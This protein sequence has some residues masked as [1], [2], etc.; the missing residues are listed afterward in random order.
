MQVEIMAGAYPSPISRQFLRWVPRLRTAFDNVC[1]LVRSLQVYFDGTLG[2]DT[3]G[4]GSIG[5]PYKTTTK[6]QAVHDAWTESATG[7]QLL[8]K[9]GTRFT[10]GLN[11][12]KKYITICDYGNSELDRPL[13]HA[14]TSSIA[15]G[16]T[17][18]TLGSGARY[19]FATANIGWIIE[20]DNP[21]K[22]YRRVAST[23]EV[24]STKN[25]FFWSSS[26]LHIHATDA[27]GQAVDPD[28]I[29]WEYTLAATTADSG[30]DITATSDFVRIENINTRG[31]GCNGSG[32]INQEYGVK[33]QLTGTKTAYIKGCGSYYNSA[34]NIG[35]NPGSGSAGGVVMFEDC[36]VG[37]CTAPDATAFISYAGNGA[38]E[39]I[40][41]NNKVKYGSLPLTAT[42]D[43]HSGVA[44]YMHTNGTAFGFGLALGNRVEAPENRFGNCGGFQF[45]NA[46]VSTS[47]AN[48]KAVAFGTIME[49][50]KGSGHNGDTTATS[51]IPFI[52]DTA[53]INCI[54]RLQ[55]L[56]ST[57]DAFGVSTS[58]R[59]YM[60]NCIYEIDLRYSTD[61]AMMMYNPTAA[62]NSPSMWHCLITWIGN[63]TTLTGMNYDNQ[64]DSDASSSFTNSA[65]TQ[66][67]NTIWQYI[68]TGSADSSSQRL[69]VPDSATNLV[70]N[71]YFGL[72]TNGTLDKNALTTNR[73]DLVTPV[74]LPASRK[75]SVATGL[76]N[77][78]ADL[79][80]EFDIFGRT[81]DTVPAVGP[82][83]NPVHENEY[84][85]LVTGYFSE[86]LDLGNLF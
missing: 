36:D 41:L 78:G 52:L 54:N 63:G 59:A 7:L 21:F 64:F 29:E 38:Q 69:R 26:T 46:P 27:Y 61:A 57:T 35:H 83:E 65:G 73:I 62:A 15:S 3:T 31:W 45:A 37:L 39:A 43:F 70:S 11:I 76:D 72:S 80:V 14:F 49:K 30:I 13:L 79:G 77:R 23:A 82:W 5:N 56:N 40:F 8:L 18:W 58:A 9:R 24:E 86:P 33:S 10:T 74:R 16:G 20:K 19:T 32:T 71:A 42:R 6:A 12:S 55:P 53:E 47:I 67:K 44:G 25:S 4:D 75:T 60:V 68:R 66:I 51:H 84:A 81:R 17:N 48:C 2:D 34:H 85:D 50:G 1:P 28:T 22:V